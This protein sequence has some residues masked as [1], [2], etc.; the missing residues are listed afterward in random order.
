M[1]LSEQ[2]MWKYNN[3]W[4]WAANRDDWFFAVNDERRRYNEDL[5]TKELADIKFEER[6]PQKEYDKQINHGKT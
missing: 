5:L 4:S 3:N 2:K 1:L 6:Y